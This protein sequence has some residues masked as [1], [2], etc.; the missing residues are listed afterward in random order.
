MIRRH[1]HIAENKGERPHGVAILFGGN[2]SRH[3]AGL[4][5]GSTCFCSSSSGTV[6]RSGYGVIRLDGGGTI[7]IFIGRAT[8]EV[9]YNDRDSPH[10]G[11]SAKLG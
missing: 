5:L 6:R 10:G 9:G 7:W 8:R 11:R 4:W 1:V 2:G 3:V